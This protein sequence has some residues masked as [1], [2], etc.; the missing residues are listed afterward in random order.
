M[1]ILDN[2]A[3]VKLDAISLFLTKTEALHL[4][5]Y[6]EQLVESTR[7]DHSHLMSEDYQKEITICL[8]DSE[9]IKN[10]EPRIQKLIKIDE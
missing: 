1:R 8:Y 5:G 6:L 7:H 3:D 10:F 4:I 9:N 2:D